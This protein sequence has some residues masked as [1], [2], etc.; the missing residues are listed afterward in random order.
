MAGFQG[1]NSFIF[2]P[3]IKPFLFAH[4]LCAISNRSIQVS[5]DL[6]DA[7]F[8]FEH[9]FPIA[10]EVIRARTGLAVKEYFKTLIDY[11]P[12]NIPQNGI[13]HGLGDLLD[14]K[15]QKWAKENLVKELLFYLK[16]YK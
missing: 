1:W 11:V 2:F 12:K 6:F 8:M 5:R 14:Q 3:Q 15:A 10:E 7:H 4:K 13:L 9:N 16:S